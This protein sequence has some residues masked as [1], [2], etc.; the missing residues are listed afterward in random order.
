MGNLSDYSCYQDTYYLYQCIKFLLNE[1]FVLIFTL[2]FSRE[3][4]EDVVKST[5]P[6]PAH[7]LNMWAQNW[8]HL[9]NMLE[10]FPKKTV[11]DVTK[12]MKKKKWK[13]KD[14]LKKAEEFF[15]SIGT[16]DLSKVKMLSHS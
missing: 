3:L 7:L 10:P 6:I 15:V 5:G 2:Q 4:G 12:E 16:F 13:K 11:P 8:G 1:D 9:Y 14:V